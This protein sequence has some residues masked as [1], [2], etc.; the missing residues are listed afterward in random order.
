MTKF[1]YFSRLLARIEDTPGSIDMTGILADFF[2]DLSDEELS[3]SV[4]FCMGRIFPAWSCTETG[5]GPSLLYTAISKAAGISVKDVE[6]L[7]KETGDVGIAACRALSGTRKGQ[8][9]FANFSEDTEHLT[10]TDVYTSL[11]KVAQASGKGSQDK[12]MA[13]LQKLF[14]EC[15][16]KE[17]IYIARLTIEELRVGVGEG[18]I[19]DS[20][21][22]AFNTSPALIERG[23]MITNDIGEVAKVA[24]KDGDCGLGKLTVTIGHPI[25]LM[26]AQRAESI[27]SAVDGMVAVEWKYDGARVQIHKNGNDIAIYSRGLENITASLPDVADMVKEHVTSDS[28]ILDGEVVAIGDD[29]KPRPFQDLLRRFRRKYDVSKMVQK[30]SVQLN[31]FDIMYLDGNPL[32]DTPLEKRHAILAGIVDE[33]DRILVARQVISSKIGRAHV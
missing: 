26:L 24:K 7:V 19:R 2:S 29:G 20:I 5:I 1:S 22:Q 30:I 28:V 4:R 9:T 25:K 21:A 6:N 12:K 11:E 31:L 23:Y 18:I 17:A 32:I 13:Y 14:S 33:K 16:P 10:I 15:E 27:T 8:V 3:I